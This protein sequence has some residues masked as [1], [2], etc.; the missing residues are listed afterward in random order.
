MWFRILQIAVGL[1]FGFA[2]IYFG[3]GEL[4]GYAIGFIAYFGA[5]L[6]TWVAYRL[7]GGGN[8]T[9]SHLGRKQ[10][11]DDSRSIIPR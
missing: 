9:I 10:S 7:L 8:H 2:A 4:N 11:T 6:V 3:N 5:Y 1:A